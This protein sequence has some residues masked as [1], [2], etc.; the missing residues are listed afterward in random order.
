M[1]LGHFACARNTHRFIAC[2]PLAGQP[3]AIAG[4][5]GPGGVTG[6]QVPVKTLRRHKA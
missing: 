6:S 5:P 4:T 1:A 2:G 3:F